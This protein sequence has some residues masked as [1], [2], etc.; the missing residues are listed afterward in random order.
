M[1]KIDR[2]GGVNQDEMLERT[3]LGLHKQS[4]PIKKERKKDLLL[5]RR[6]GTDWGGGGDQRNG[7]FVPG[8]KK[9]R[10]GDGGSNTWESAARRGGLGLHFPKG[11]GEN[12]KP[13][14]EANGVFPHRAPG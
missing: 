4:A 8:G 11:G 6:F 10:K 5:R 12:K 13:K 9:G 2:F 14:G 1:I 7:T 3:G